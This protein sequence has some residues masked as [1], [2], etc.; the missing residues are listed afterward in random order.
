VRFVNCLPGNGIQ[1]A[2]MFTARPHDLL[3]LSGSAALPGDA[4]AWAV[5]I[6]RVVP[7]VVV[8]RGPASD[9][10][11]PVG[12]RGT[13]RSERYGTQVALEDVREVV[14]P[15]A[16][17]H[18]ST[19]VRDLPALRTLSA[20]RPLL[21]SVG[22]VWGPTGSVGFELA[23]GQPTAT[24]DSD[25]DLLIRTPHG[26][27]DMLPALRRLHQ[28]FGSLP[29]RVDCQIELSTGA[30]ALAELIGSKPDIMI[31]TADGPRLVARAVAVS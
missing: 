21:D 28:G 3:R 7:W 29:A 26:V 25:L 20:V 24:P 15:G 22:L 2:D 9:R 23:T 27:A 17:A 30:I 13:T 8:R 18:V 6:L 16:L 31:R 11:I 4:P 1:L 14:A 5:H 19:L 10:L 12:V